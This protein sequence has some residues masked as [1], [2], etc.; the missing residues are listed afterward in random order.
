[1][2]KSDQKEVA[3]E[4]SHSELDSLKKI[5]DLAGVQYHPNIGVDKLKEKIEEHLAK[6][7]EAPVAPQVIHQVVQQVVPQEAVKS[8]EISAEERKRIVREATKLVRVRIT[9]MNAAKKEW[10]GEVFTV[11]NSIIPTQKKY[12]PFNNENGWH[13]P[14]IMLNMIKERKCQVFKTVKR[15]GKEI[16]EAFL[17]PEFSIE[18]MEP[19]TAAQLQELKEEQAA[20]HR[21]D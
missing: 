5:A 14:Q 11:S 21:I 18:I 12:V 10:P 3:T 9:C 7:K 19:L 4:A 1:M 15:A 13:I 6:P 16:K 2:S 8:N 20:A 17:I